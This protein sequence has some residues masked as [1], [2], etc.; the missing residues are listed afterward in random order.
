M[1]EAEDGPPY[2]A[3]IVL[4]RLDTPLQEERPVCGGPVSELRAA[5]VGGATTWLSEASDAE[6]VWRGEGEIWT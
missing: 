5:A 4:F 2:H 6:A 1:V 3:C